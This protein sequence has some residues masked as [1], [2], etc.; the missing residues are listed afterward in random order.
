MTEQD[1][2]T[3]GAL[4]FWNVDRFHHDPFLSCVIDSRT[5]RYSTA[6]F[7]SS[8]L[9]LAKWFVDGGLQPGDRVAIYSE[10]R[11]EWHIVDF[12]AHLAGLILVPV[13][14]T[15]NAHQMQHIL[16]HSGARVVFCGPPQRER[17][18]A[19]R[20]RLRTLE[21]VL[22]LERAD[23]AA[24]LETL[25]AEL[26]PLS[27][28]ERTRFRERAFSSDPESI[29]TIVYTSGTTGL[30]KG[31]MLKQR[32]IMFDLRG[33]I[34]CLPDRRDGHALSVLP[35][36]HVF[37][38]ILCYGYFLRG[39][40]ISYGD[41]H[42]L[43]DLLN[44]YHPNILGV[45]PRILE[46]MREAIETTV[47]KMPA[48]RQAISRF[49]L[50]VGYAELDGAGGW[51]AALHPVAKALMFRK[52]RSQLG[53]VE[54][55]VSGGAWLNPQLERYFRAMGFTVLQGYG[56]TE[57]SPVIACNRAGSERTGS[58]GRPIDGVDVRISDDGEIVTRG[59][60]VMA[61]YYNDPESTQKA[62]QDGWFHTGDLGSID[63][64]GYLTITGRRKEMLVL[65]NGKNIFYAPIEQALAKSDLIDQAFIVGEG[66]NY[67]T[68]ILIPNM[69][70]LLRHAKERG[71]LVSTEEE[72]LLAGPVI[73]LYRETLDALQAE[74]S[75]F[76][77]AKRFCFLRE[78]ALLDGELVT[79]SHK[80]RRNVLERKYAHQVERM[81]Q[82]EAPFVIPA[83]DSRPPAG[84]AA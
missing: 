81:Y 47:S 6:E 15:L 12:A 33:S 80:V 55:F 37:E 82:Q 52:V 16:E 20:S 10:N 1:I 14:P 44:L 17:V 40:S 58:V 61:G 41:P 36:S 30:P 2:Q 34:Q 69:V 83:P 53:G 64:A 18:E 72:L 22:G 21:H 67:T 42:N 63:S 75:R 56:L 38:R 25:L 84:R 59:S 31:V 3:L 77:Q 13:Y 26:P 49:L 45:V 79:P 54:I 8:V 50:D 11:P 29:A 74:F 51:K 23:S 7:E 28:D 57:T 39:I 35:L 19:V 62:I 78:E 24:N 70:S 32:N 43:R 66:R 48:H 76:E 65:S 68:A 71:I 5:V 60:H 73:A 9:R 46:K 4:F 27:P